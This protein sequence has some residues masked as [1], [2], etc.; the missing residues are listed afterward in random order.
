MKDKYGNEIFLTIH[1]VYL[2]KHDCKTPLGDR[3]GTIGIDV[4]YTH[5]NKNK[6]FHRGSNSFGFNEKLLQLPRI[7]K[8]VLNVDNTSKYIIPKEVILKEGKILFEQQK[9]Y[10]KDIFLSMEIIKQYKYEPKHK[11]TTL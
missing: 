3:L 1:A 9:G 5:R 10:T 7:N 4:L 2:L 11:S 8:V 6:D